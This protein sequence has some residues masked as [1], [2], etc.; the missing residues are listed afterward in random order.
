MWRKEN[1]SS[2]QLVGLY[3]CV[4]TMEKQYEGSSKN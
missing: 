1:S 2:T 4:D 3:L